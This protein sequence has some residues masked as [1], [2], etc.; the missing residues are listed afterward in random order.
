MIHRLHPLPAPERRA[1]FPTFLAT[2]AEVDNGAARLVSAGGEPEPVLGHISSVPALQVNDRV[3]A[4]RVSEGVVIVG[5]MRRAGEAP[6][7]SVV[8]EGGQVRIEA[9]RS[10]TLRSGLSCVELTADGRISVDGREVYS[11]ADGRMVLQ[12]ATIELN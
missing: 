9:G 4:K 12:G 10:L 5:R 11:F 8:E 2:V 6:Q 1:D 7:A 3:L